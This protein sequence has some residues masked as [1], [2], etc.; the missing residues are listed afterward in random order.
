[1]KSGQAGSNYI[2]SSILALQDNIG[3]ISG[4]LLFLPG[5]P[6]PHNKHINKFITPLSWMKHGFRVRAEI[7]QQADHL[8][9][10]IILAWSKYTTNYKSIGRIL[11][12]IFKEEDI[13]ISF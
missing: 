13:L 5:I 2:G 11:V 9:G 1:M 3:K 6:Q 10:S 7:I 8:S 12:D 4:S